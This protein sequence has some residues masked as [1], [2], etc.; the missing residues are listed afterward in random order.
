MP[1]IQK[2]DRGTKSVRDKLNQMV[3]AL[4]SLDRFASDGLIVIKRTASGLSFSIATKL[5][6]A[7]MPKFTKAYFFARLDNENE[8]GDY[9]WEEVWRDVGGWTVLAD[10]R[11]GTP[12][13]G[14]AR[15]LNGAGGLYNDDSGVVDTVV[16]MFPIINDDGDT[17]YRFICAAPPGSMFTVEVTKTAG[18]E[19]DSSTLCTYV[20]TVKDMS[21]TTTLGE[22]MEPIKWRNDSA[23]RK[24]LEGSGIGTAYHDSAGDIVLFDA[25]EVPAVT[26][27]P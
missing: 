21:G 15:E 25:N 20:Y 1:R 11:S 14:P 18:V 17:I 5:L 8:S 23:K 13:V 7:K 22:G 3:D 4:N 26:V 16:L 9:G 12:D 6:R 2:F 10:G 27:C 24:M 19:G